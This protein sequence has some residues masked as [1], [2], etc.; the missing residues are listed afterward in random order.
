MKNKICGELPPSLQY[1]V[2]RYLGKTVRQFE[3]V[4]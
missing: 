2:Y 3:N 1:E 4:T